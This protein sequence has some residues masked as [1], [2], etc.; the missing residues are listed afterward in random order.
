M[1]TPRQVLVIKDDP[2]IA[3][4]LMDDLLQDGFV[5]H[6][7]ADGS[8]ALQRIQAEPPALAILNLM[9]PGLDG[10]RVGAAMPSLRCMAWATAWTHC[11]ELPGPIRALGGQSGLQAEF[12]TTKRRA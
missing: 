4:L 9:L 6:L 3:Q 5:G 10:G 8:I 12:S 2:K 1:T 11:C 7:V